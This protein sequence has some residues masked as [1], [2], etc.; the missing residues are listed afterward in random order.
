M[1]P[2]QAHNASNGGD[3]SREV[4]RLTHIG[5]RLPCGRSAAGIF[6]L[7]FPSQAKLLRLKTARPAPAIR[8][9]LTDIHFRL[10]LVL[11]IW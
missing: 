3:N 1:N 9:A 11:P 8:T 7:N 2:Q 10:R 5:T 4:H 6:Y